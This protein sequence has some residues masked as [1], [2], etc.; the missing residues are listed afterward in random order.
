MRLLRAFIDWICRKRQ[1]EQETLQHSADDP[2]VLQQIEK[3]ERE[4]KR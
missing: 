4:L 1:P 3:F 2:W